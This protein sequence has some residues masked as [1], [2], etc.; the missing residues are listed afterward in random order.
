M[1]SSLSMFFK[2]G[3]L[4]TLANFTGKQLRWSLFNKVVGL[5]AW[6]VIKNRL[7]QRCFSVKFAKFLRTTFFTEHL[8]WLLLEIDISPSFHFYCHNYSV[9]N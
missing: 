3:V 6:S 2:I 9:L 8:R 7:Q 4:K 1:Q 5:K